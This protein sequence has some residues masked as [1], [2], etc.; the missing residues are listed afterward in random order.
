M[1][2]EPLL[3]VEPA[4][5]AALVRQLHGV[6]RVSLDAEGNGLFA[7]RARLCT[8]QLAWESGDEV[9]VAIVD[10]IRLD[11]AALA[12]LLG[13]SG[14]IKLLHDCTFDVKLLADSNVSLA[15]VRDTSVLA[16]MLGRKATGLAS[17]LAAELGI[18]LAKELQQHDWSRRPFEPRQIEYLADDVRH[19]MA[20]DDKLAA[21]ARALDIEE[22]VEV[23]CLFKVEGAVAP[24]RERKPAY[25]RIR[26]SEKLDKP[27]L[28][29]LRHLVEARE[30]ISADWDQPPFKVASNDWLLALA[31]GKPRDVREL[32]RFRGSFSPRIM[33]SAELLVAAVNAGL[34][35]LEPPPLPAEPR[36]DKAI[37]AA[38]RSREKRLSAWRRKEAAARGVD[39]QA[40]LPGHCLQELAAMEADEIDAIDRVPGLGEKRFRR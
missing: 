21:E 13:P 23:E 28:A 38:R 18:T 15:R 31:A 35:E 14:P 26:G 2:S 8:L 16:R 40:V 27:G 10:T 29:V 37:A 30:K 6:P 3:V 11:P 19:L 9:H 20:L 34:V 33:G 12:D 24:P 17:L 25:L 1:P 32:R 36:L 7:Y 4:A 22:E 5:L 39:E